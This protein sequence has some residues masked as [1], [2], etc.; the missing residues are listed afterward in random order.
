MS[1]IKYQ[2]VVIGANG[3]TVSNLTGI[4]ATNA[5]INFT[6][7]IAPIY[8]IG[9]KSAV[10]T[11]PNA[12]VKGA[13]SI[14]YYL[15]GTDPL[16]GAWRYAAT[17]GDL[18]TPMTV[19][20]NNV[21][22]TGCYLRNYSANASANQV[23]TANVEWDVYMTEGQATTLTAGT[24]LA[25]GTP[26]IG[27]GAATSGDYNGV[28]VSNAISFNL[29]CTNEYQETYIMGATTPIHPL[30]KSTSSQTLTLEGYNLAKTVTACGTAATGVVT[31]KDV[32]SANTVETFTVA[33]K[34]QSSNLT[35]ANNGAV[36][37]S[38]T[39]L[40]NNY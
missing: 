33:G 21:V 12:P 29:Q 40:D 30:V 15:T 5:N 16:Y 34:I 24:S 3:W 35:L 11:P 6:N 31:L 27:H 26:D 18:S 10:A 17:G 20:W 32:C 14:T 25:P 9:R 1:V 23:A 38:I 28:A 19:G 36:Q 39:I 7:A 8:A 4:F 2:D 13:T 22:L 37:G